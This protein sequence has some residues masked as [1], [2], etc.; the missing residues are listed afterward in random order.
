MARRLALPLQLAT[1]GTFVTVAQDSP[2]DISQSVGLLLATRPGERRSV[3]GYGLPDPLFS[4]LDPDLVAAVI[5]EWEDRADPAG[6]ELV[7]TGVDEYGR[8]YPAIPAP[9]DTSPASED[10]QPEGV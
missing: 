1:S 4:G 5:E 7:A 9:D 10:Q 8:V 6:I 3:P 2:A